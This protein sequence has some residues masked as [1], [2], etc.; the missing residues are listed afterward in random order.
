MPGRLHGSVVPIVRVASDGAHE[1]AGT[2]IVVSST[3]VITCLHVIRTG[4]NAVLCGDVLCRATRIRT[5]DEWDLCCLSFD[6]LPGA[7]P[8]PLFRAHG[9]KGCL[10][11]A[12]GPNAEQWIPELEV[13]QEEKWKGWLR[14]AQLKGG[15][16][17]GFSG[18]PVLARA[19]GAWRAA[20]MLFLGREEAA[21]S[22][23]IAVDLIAEFLAGEG[24][25]VFE[26]PPADAGCLRIPSRQWIEADHGPAALLRAEYEIVPFGGRA[27]ELADIQG[28]AF[29]DRR[30]GVR[31]YHERG[32][33]GKTR[34]ALEACKRLQQENVR[35]GF[36]DS[37]ASL[38]RIRNLLA[39]TEDAGLARLFA[40]IDYA[41]SDPGGLKNLIGASEEFP[42]MHVR[43]MLLARGLGN[44]W[45]A[46]KRTGDGVGEILMGP[47]TDTPIHLGPIGVSDEFRAGEFLRAATAFAGLLGRKA[48]KCD[49]IDLSAPLFER[50]LLLHTH[51]LLTVMEVPFEVRTED[52]DAIL[53]ALLGREATFLER[54][55]RA[56]GLDPLL[57]DAALQA[58]A[59]I[60][61]IGGVDDMANASGVIRALPA[62]KGTSELAVDAL[63]RLL[64]GAYGGSKWIDPLQPD[65]L[66]E[67]A[68]DKVFADNPAALNAVLTR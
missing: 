45:E 54:V 66:G 55:I 49:G 44:W 51:A 60:T 2:G 1:V 61:A 34:L 52:S 58:T 59:A 35:A 40:V 33:V 57:H 39:A 14:T 25:S 43:I 27:Q 63:A 9:L 50:A 7:T 11:A 64:H 3:A 21:T 53:D 24:V 68:M 47:A 15:V 46:A 29:S 42:A 12:A 26:L 18:A 41:E 56:R 19:E 23:M 4:A 31:L 67:Y 65:I 6:E 17:R 16:R 36:L 62:L 32:G 48:P 22:R 37:S 13:I 20:G 5:S 30:I 28:W 10:L 38:D 8:M